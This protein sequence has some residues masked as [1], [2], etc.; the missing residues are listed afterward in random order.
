MDQMNLSGFIGVGWHKATS[1]WRAFISL[2]GRHIHLGY[3]SDKVMAALAR[4]KAARES[5]GEYAVL[6]F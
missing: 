4:D 3:F 1:K 2:N 6:N 5:Y